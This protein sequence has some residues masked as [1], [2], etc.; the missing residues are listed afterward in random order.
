MLNLSFVTG[1]EPGK[2]FDRYRDR[3]G[4]GLAERNSDDPMAELLGGEADLVLVRLPDERVDT[5]RLHVVRLYEEATG[6]AVPKDHT[7]TLV[8]AVGEEDLEG[9]MVLYRWTG[10]LVDIAAVRGHLQVVAANVGLVIAPRPLLKVL[11]G[12]QIEVRGFE[13]E[14]ARSGIALVWDK[15]Q[16]SEAI[17]DFVGIAKGRTVHSSRQSAP[18]K[19]AKKKPVARKSGA[20]RAEKP[21]RRRR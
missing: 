13:G 16:D 7:L 19:A 9:E 21:R 4:H 11:S 2:W 5:E 6:I 20:K 18:K 1:T 3:T 14:A 15:D 8:E 10:G 17:Q 12:K